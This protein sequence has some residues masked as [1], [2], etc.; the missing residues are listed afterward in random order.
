[1]NRDEI[2]DYYKEKHAKDPGF[3]KGSALIKHIPKI[4]EYIQTFEYRSI[5]DYGC[6]K[7]LFWKQDKIFINSLFEWHGVH[8]TIDLYDPAIPEYQ[9]LQNRRYDMVIC[10]D[11][12]EHV[13]EEDVPDTLDNILTRVRKMAY[14][15]IS[16]KPATKTFNNGSNVHVTIRDRLWWQKQIKQSE[17][18]TMEKTR[19]YMSIACFFDD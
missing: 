14:L 6:G 15:N 1:M 19:Q 16:T 12:L 5:L 7:A 4:A 13:L 10:T 9:I 18:R 2:L 11:V 17:E 3:S 8:G